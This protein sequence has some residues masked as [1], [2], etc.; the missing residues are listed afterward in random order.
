MKTLESSDGTARCSREA[1]LYGMKFLKFFVGKRVGTQ[2]RAFS[3]LLTVTEVQSQL[4]NLS[5]RI[6][7]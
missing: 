6:Y 4:D 5:A 1:V 3:A 7:N 2:K